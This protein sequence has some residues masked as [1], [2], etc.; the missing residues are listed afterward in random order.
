MLG[1]AHAAANPLTARYGITHGLAV[2]LMIAS[3]IRHNAQ[4]PKINTLYA[5]LARFAG[6]AHHDHPDEL[7]TQCLIKRLSELLQTSQL[8]QTLEKYNLEDIPLKELATQAAKQWTAQFNPRPIASEDFYNL[9]HES[10][11]EFQLHHIGSRS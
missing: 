9:Y 10:F 4:D 2:G 6:L 7:A 3:I 1:G 8:S 5:D 11:H